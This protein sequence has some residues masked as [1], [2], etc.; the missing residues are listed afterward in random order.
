MLWKAFFCLMM[1]VLWITGY[2][3]ITGSRDPVFTLR[4]IKI[5]GWVFVITR[6]FLVFADKEQFKVFAALIRIAF[7]GLMILL[8][9]YAFTEQYGVGWYFIM[10]GCIITME[11]ILQPTKMIEQ[12]SKQMG[13]E[14]TEEE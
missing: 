4:V 2:F 14:K 3:S 9:Y 1:M 10:V 11:F 12:M 6:F 13:I 8:G 7:V 5:L